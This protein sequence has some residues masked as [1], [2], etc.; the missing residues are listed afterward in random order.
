MDLDDVIPDFVF[1]STPRSR[2]DS[3]MAN[4]LVPRSPRHSKEGKSKGIYFIREADY[5]QMDCMEKSNHFANDEIVYLKVDIREVKHL[6][7]P[8]PEW[9][10][11]VNLQD[12]PRLMVDDIAW[13]IKKVVPPACIV[14][15]FNSIQECK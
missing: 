2:L 9:R 12:D 3:I 10:P 7:K 6:L 4:G 1:H 13:Y 15:V 5:L 11:Y 8:D 14:N